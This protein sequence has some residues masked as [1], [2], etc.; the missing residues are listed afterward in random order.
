[1][2]ITKLST[3]SKVLIA[4]LSVVILTGAIFGATQMFAE[5]TLED[6]CKDYMHE[7]G[8]F[9]PS[10]L[11]EGEKVSPVAWLN[12]TQIFI[13]YDCWK[14]VNGDGLVQISDAYAHQDILQNMLMNHVLMPICEIEGV[15]DY[16]IIS[17][18][19]YATY[20]GILLE[21]QLGNNNNNAE[22]KSQEDY[23][24]DREN[25]HLYIRK[26]VID[27][28][29]DKDEQFP[30]RAESIM[31]VKNIETT[32]KK[33]DIATSFSAD[34]DADYTQIDVPN[35]SYEFN[36]KNWELNGL[37]I[38]LIQAKDLSKIR[39]EDIGVAV[40]GHPTDAW[41]YNEFDGT[42]TIACN[43][44]DTYYVEIIINDICDSTTMQGVLQSYQHKN[45]QDVGFAATADEE[46]FRNAFSGDSLFI[47]NINYEDGPPVE[48]TTDKMG[49]TYSVDFNKTDRYV[50]EATAV[51]NQTKGDAA[52]GNN[53][54]IFWEVFEP[55]LKSVPTSV[56]SGSTVYLQTT[57]INAYQSNDYVTNWTQDYGQI[58]YNTFLFGMKND[59]SALDTLMQYASSAVTSQSSYP[60]WGSN[61]NKTHTMT[62]WYVGSA[63]TIY[64][65]GSSK[66]AYDED[67]FLGGV[68]SEDSVA[69]FDTNCCEIIAPSADAYYDM[70]Y[71]GE[72]TVND[73]STGK[74]REPQYFDDYD[75]NV[76]IIDVA[77]NQDG[78]GGYLYL[79]VYSRTMRMWKEG[80][81]QRILSF[82]R[83][84]Y[85][86]NGGTGK[87]S[88][89]KTDAVTG[90]PVV[91]AIYTIYNENGE[92]VGTIE[93]G[94]DAVESISLPSGNYYVEETSVPEGYLKDT[95][96]HPVTIQNGKTTPMTLTDEPQ[97]L[98]LTFTVY[99]YTTKGTGYEVPVAG[100][101]FELYDAGNNL[102]GT[103]ITNDKGQLNDSNNYI[104]SEGDYYI[105][106]PAT[107]NYYLRQIGTVQ[108]YSIE[109]DKNH[110][111]Y[112]EQIKTVIN[113]NPT[114]SGNNLSQKVVHYE[115]RQSVKLT[116]QVQDANLGANSPAVLGGDPTSGSYVS[117]INSRYQLKNTSEIFLGCYR[118]EKIYAPAGQIL[119]ID[120]W[121]TDQSIVS[122][123]EAY[124]KMSSNDNMAYIVATGVTYNYKGNKLHF[125]LP[126]GTYEWIQTSASHG[127]W[128]DGSRTAI[129]LSWSSENDEL[130]EW[131]V[132]SLPVSQKR[133]T[134][135]YNMFV[136]SYESDSRAQIGVN[137]TYN[138]LTTQHKTGVYTYLKP[139][140]IA[141][142]SAPTTEKWVQGVYTNVTKDVKGNS[143]TITKD[144]VEGAVLY[145]N[146]NMKLAVSTSGWVPNMIYEFVNLCDIVDINTGKIIPA[147]TTLGYYKAD[148][149]G[150][151]SVVQ[152]GSTSFSNPNTNVDID[153]VSKVE[154]VTLSN[155]PTFGNSLPN[156]VYALTPFID[157]TGYKAEKGLSEEISVKLQWLENTSKQE[158][159]SETGVS[160]VW[161]KDVVP[162]IDTIIAPDPTSKPNDPYDPL[163]PD[164]KV[165]D[166]D[167][168]TDIGLVTPSWI[169]KHKHDI[170]YRI[171]DSDNFVSENSETKYDVRD[172]LPT[173]FAFYFNEKTEKD[174]NRTYRYFMSFYYEAS[175]QEYQEALNAGKTVMRMQ[176]G[177]YAIK[178]DDR[179]TDSLTNYIVLNEMSDGYIDY[180]ESEANKS[181]SGAI[182][183]AEWLND[184]L[185]TKINGTYK[186]YIVLQV[187]ES[188]PA[189]YS[190][191][192]ITSMQP[193]KYVGTLT[194]KNRQ[195][196]NLD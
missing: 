128:M 188:Y 143:T 52:P 141:S 98:A 113:A 166:A 8:T 42:L 73:P 5:P 81:K 37:S 139:K 72:H 121:V 18:T 116:T 132:K 3:T 105:L 49:W 15:E 154:P 174:V 74:P 62:A 152:I 53:A 187:Q 178:F 110:S 150:K 29:L 176:D 82:V 58:V 137:S 59:K 75:T 65:T 172:L 71:N 183:N 32:T 99:D 11:Y 170:A 153:S 36:I 78:T 56:G 26:S 111:E 61:P 127:Y 179:G 77:E 182:Y 7:I 190:G 193:M 25:N 186:I 192:I 129:D 123:T 157:A 60:M 189:K 54:S 165:L 149:N 91:G 95:T 48:G 167:D 114:Q 44:Y 67:G 70:F 118:G 126:N 86:Y 30:I 184:R 140:S 35:N 57:A 107:G 102:Y 87:I 55:V 6:L 23:Y 21:L 20:N 85:T 39:T 169:D 159:L 125:D 168:S 33:I 80:H 155:T 9:E 108:N 69:W 133:Q 22:L 122:S 104:D 96:R 4:I 13:A 181:V 38:Q 46:A 175:Q 34:I 79:C 146:G 88:I 144:S 31:V 97:Q 151:I 148:A 134:V 17:Y 92:A 50:I 10:K 106:I 51:T 191:T 195:L 83:V 156:G 89:I 136:K 135:E 24:Y 162:E 117:L 45:D 19:D 160:F 103:Y 145:E 12:T 41:I 173:T 64:I 177:T 76:T 40:N 2:K 130:Q 28:N 131:A 171:F 142:S 124:S 138:K 84:P 115:Q 47:K 100:V 66:L 16:Y 94:I 27:Q 109:T 112:C 164:D 185:R 101:T 180:G 1:M 194:I 161:D 93:T 14:D 68:L 163:N 63:E 147:R 119:T 120:T 158:K 90:L 43:Y 196:V